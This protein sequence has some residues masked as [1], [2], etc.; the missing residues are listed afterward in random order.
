MEVSPG[1]LQSI[2]GLFCFVFDKLGL[3]QVLDL[4]L[5]KSIPQE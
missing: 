3:N 2:A 1:K 5:P 4:E